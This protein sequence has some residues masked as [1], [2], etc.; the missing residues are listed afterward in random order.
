MQLEIPSLQGPRNRP[1]HS[2]L[3][4]R[5]MTATY[6]SKYYRP[7]PPAWQHQGTTPQPWPGAHG[8]CGLIPSHAPY[9]PPPASYWCPPPLAPQTNF[10]NAGYYEGR[11]GWGPTGAYGGFRSYTPHLPQINRS[12]GSSP[13]VAAMEA[14]PWIRD[15]SQ[16][17][18]AYAP[19][20]HQGYPIPNAGVPIGMAAP[21]EYRPDVRFAPETANQYHSHNAL[22][23][24]SGGGSP[25]SLLAPAAELAIAADSKLESDS[26]RMKERS[27][28][29]NSSKIE[30]SD[31]GNERKVRTH[32]CAVCGT[33]FFSKQV[34]LYN[35][36]RNHTD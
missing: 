22:S 2:Q 28:N 14:P 36:L 30:D 7:W 3:T 8:D 20:G 4:L 31:Q 12:S 24:C 10:P 29:P 21:T 34:G 35:R 26:E 1:A 11:Y 16:T 5:R 13:P 32:K 27:E 17:I 15:A 33:K 18:G 25:V 6:D 23:S 9:L 19:P